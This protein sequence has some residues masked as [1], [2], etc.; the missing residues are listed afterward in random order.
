MAEV[1]G[2]LAS[3]AGIASLGCQIFKSIYKLQQV[4]TAIRNAPQELKTI[5]EE[6]A[7]VTTILIHISE[8]PHPY[9]IGRSQ[10]VARDQALVYCET[11]CRQ[12]FTVVSGIENEIGESKCRSRW[13]CFLTV[14]KAKKITDLVTR[15][16]RAKSILALA[17]LMY[18]Q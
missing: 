7:L 13:Y 17:Q 6:I 2:I 10:S 16:E 9:T 5:L 3:G 1:V 4:L 14:L 11:A 18:L 15:L 12:L 8:R